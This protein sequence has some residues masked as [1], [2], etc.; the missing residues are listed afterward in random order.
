[1]VKKKALGKGLDVLFPEERGGAETEGTKE[2]IKFEGISYNLDAV[3]RVIADARRNPRISLWSPPSAAVLR[4]LRK[5]KP[6]FSISE[7][8][9][10]LLEEGVRKKYPELYELVK[11]EAK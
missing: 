10:N 1:M 5:T 8:A 3:R 11:R 2:A 4:Y 7:E 6:E 9:G